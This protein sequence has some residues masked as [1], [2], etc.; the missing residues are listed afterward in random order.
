MQWSAIVLSY[1]A[2][3]SISQDLSWFRTM[4]QRS[5]MKQR[6]WQDPVRQLTLTVALNEN[7][8]LNYFFQGH[9][10]VLGGGHS[11]I[12]CLIITWN[13]EGHWYNV[14]YTYLVGG[15]QIEAANSVK[16]MIPS[17][18]RSHSR[19]TLFASL[20]EFKACG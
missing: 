12:V 16:S 5:I 20:L 18:L 4:I 15:I 1:I 7:K 17:L 3:M 14:L 2:S 9:H 19:N 8:C 6:T 13:Y 11:E 10:I